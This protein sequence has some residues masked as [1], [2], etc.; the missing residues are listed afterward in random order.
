MG[1][2][3]EGSEAGCI[4]GGEEENGFPDVLPAD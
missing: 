3:K 4:P 2:C 1:T